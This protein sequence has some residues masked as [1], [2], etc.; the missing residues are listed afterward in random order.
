MFAGASHPDIASNSSLIPDGKLDFAWKLSGDRA[1]A[2]LQVFSDSSH[3]W[4]HWHP[5]QSVPA[6]L[7]NLGDQEK[8]LSYKRQDPYTIIEGHWP[9]LSFRAG[10][11]QAFARRTQLQIDSPLQRSQVPTQESV[12]A[13]AAVL[14]PS[15]STAYAVSPEDQHVRQALIRWSGISGWRFQPEHWGVDVDIPL[16]ASASFSDDFVTS[17]QALL[18]TTE[19]SDRPLQPCFYS[20]QVLRVVAY[21]ESCDRTIVPGAPV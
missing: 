16:S 8:V 18:L 17:V 19:L 14:P 7:A 21:A 20:N 2:P 6:I 10:R 4:L 11:Q 12:K 5:N 1:V 15:S 3:T 13:P 9:R